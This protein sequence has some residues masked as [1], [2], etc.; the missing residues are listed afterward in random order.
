M[1]LLFAGIAAIII[2]AQHATLRYRLTLD[3]EVEGLRASGSSVIEVSYAR[4]LKVLGASAERTASVRGEAVAVEFGASG[5]VVALLAANGKSPTDPEQL[6]LSAFFGSGEITFDR[7]RKLAESGDEVDLPPSL[8]PPVVYLRSANDPTSVE[9]LTQQGG[10]G[11]PVTVLGIRLAVVNSGVWPLN[12]VDLT[13]VQITRGLD[14][15]LPWLNDARSRD[16]FWQSLIR[17]GF[18]SA[19]SIDLKTMF[20]RGL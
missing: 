17:S 4:N 10:G 8:F 20:V 7:I 19:G 5:I 3:A 1:G 9:F 12:T 16:R 18:R 11:A 13:G 2:H 15:R 14:R 6:A